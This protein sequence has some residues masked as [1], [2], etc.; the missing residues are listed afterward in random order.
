MTND[1]RR[2]VFIELGERFA[3]CANAQKNWTD[4]DFQRAYKCTKNESLM[5]NIKYFRAML[6]DIDV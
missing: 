1:E 5:S 6:F 3:H 2:K 4:D